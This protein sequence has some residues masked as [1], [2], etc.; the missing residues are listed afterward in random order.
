MQLRSYPMIVL[1]RTLAA[2]IYAL[3]LIF[4]LLTAFFTWAAMQKW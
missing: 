3:A 1:R 2:P 4:H